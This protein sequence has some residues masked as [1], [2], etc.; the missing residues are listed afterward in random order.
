MFERFYQTRFSP[1]SN[2]QMVFMVELRRI[3]Q[4]YSVTSIYVVNI[5]K[6]NIGS[7]LYLILSAN[8]NQTTD[9]HT[10]LRVGREQACQKWTVIS[11]GSYAH[12]AKVD[13]LKSVTD[14]E[15]LCH[16]NNKLPTNF[17]RTDFPQ[18]TY[19]WPAPINDTC[20]QESHSPPPEPHSIHFEL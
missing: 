10:K 6:I 15:I 3:P 12:R 18:P 9:H 7:H 16:M 17:C 11:F 13:H 4:S 1:L 20:L 2:S 14:V 8:P 19:S 5:P